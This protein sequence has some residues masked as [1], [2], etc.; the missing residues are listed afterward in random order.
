VPAVAF[1]AVVLP[2][3]T[4]AFVA[5]VPATPDADVGGVIIG[6]VEAAGASP[7]QPKADKPNA[8]NAP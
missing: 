5:A 1:V 3:A 2:P 4:P 8:N 6:K 7:L